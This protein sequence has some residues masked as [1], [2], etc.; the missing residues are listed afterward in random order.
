MILLLSVIHLSPGPG[1]IALSFV[2]SCVCPCPLLYFIEWFLLPPEFLGAHGPD[3]SKLYEQPW[4]LWSFPCSSVGNESASNAGDLGSVPGLGRSPGEGN[5]N[6][7]EYSC[8]ENPMD[9]ILP[10]S[11]IHGVARVRHDL[12][13]KPPA[14]AFASHFVLISHPL[15]CISIP[16]APRFQIEL[17]THNHM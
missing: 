14:P 17:T 9:C 3:S 8:L 16:Y 2:I 5:G 10:G 1:G 4:S 11:S 12:A 13:T 15:L 6:P 7:L